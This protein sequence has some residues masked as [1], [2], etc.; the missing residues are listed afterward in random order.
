MTQQTQV[1][2][3]ISNMSAAKKLVEI[4]ILDL[5]AGKKKYCNL[6]LN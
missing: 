3:I 5:K 2:A 4:K 6:I 1:I